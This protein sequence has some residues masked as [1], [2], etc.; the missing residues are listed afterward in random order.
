M[1]E[2]STEQSKDLWTSFLDLLSRIITPDWSDVI[3]WLPLGITALVLLFLAATAYRWWRASEINRSRVP[4]PLP[5][6]APPPGVHLPGPSRWPFVLPIGA[7]LIFFALVLRPTGP[8]GNV[9]GPVNLPLLAAGHAV[10]ALGVAG[11]LRDAMRE[12]RRAE[13]VPEEGGG[14]SLVG[15]PEPAQAGALPAHATA[16]TAV[17]ALRPPALPAVAASS[18]ALAPSGAT[19]EARF[20]LQPPPGVHVPGPSPWPFLAPI[21]LMVVFFGLVLSPA[22]VIGGILMSLI[23]AAGWLRDAGSEYRQ[24][25]AGHAPEPATRDPERAFPKRL[26]GL[27]AAIFAVSLALVAAPGIIAFA[28]RSQAATTGGEPGGGTTSDGGAG[29]APSDR[30]SISA[31][32]IKFNLEEFKVPAGKPFTIVFDNREPIPHNVAIYDTAQLGKDFFIGEIIT[33]PRSVTYQVPALS[34]GEY[35]FLCTVH[36]NMNGTV[37]AE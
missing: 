26:V 2:Q 17:G 16:G 28:N 34:A 18:A 11:W 31:D 24:V 21:G 19:G 10:T 13:G 5:A 3:A 23:A 29:G 32:R 4:R 8:D 12:W 33:G 6:G 27:Y 1:P 9:T 22:I 14:G 30:I 37:T 36:A 7:T 15:L 25:E 20:E 35:Y